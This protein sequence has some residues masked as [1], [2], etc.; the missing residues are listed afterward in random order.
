MV[1][2]VLC[3]QEPRLRAAALALTGAD[4]LPA[5]LDP[6]RSVAGIAPRPVLFV[7]ARSD[8]SAS[9]SP[10]LKLFEA[11]GEPK[12]LHWVDGSPGALLDDEAWS[13][14]H[15]FLREALAR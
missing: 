6:A 7:S 1:G 8:A 10:V 3:A 11:A 12:Q 14:M 5:E 15:R 4:G 9:A 13:A 2:S